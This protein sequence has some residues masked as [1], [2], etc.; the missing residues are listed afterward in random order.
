MDRYLA[1]VLDRRKVHI[2]KTVE[3]NLPLPK[4]STLYITGYCSKFIRLV[5]FTCVF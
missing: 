5:L 2:D 4:Y 3:V 1:I